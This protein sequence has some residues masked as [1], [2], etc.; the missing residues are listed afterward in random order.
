MK[1]DHYFEDHVAEFT[2]Y[3]NIKI[4]DF[5]KPDSNEYRMRF[6]FEEDYYRLHISGDFGELTALSYTNMTFKK[7]ERD[8]VNDTGYFQSK[9]MAHSRPLYEYSYEVAEKELE[10]DEDIKCYAECN[11]ISVSEVV[12]EILIDFSE[13]NGIGEGGMDK[14]AEIMGDMYEAYGKAGAIG[15]T[16]TGILELYMAAFKLAIRQLEGK[17]YD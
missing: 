5:K 4:L 1:Y 9:V 8:Y 3:G 12:E 16:S 17:I 15:Y 7:F 11:N 2:D 10:N 6:L 14:V 13:E